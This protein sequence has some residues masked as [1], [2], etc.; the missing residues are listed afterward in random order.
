[1]RQIYINY[2]YAS[3]NIHFSPV[4][5]CSALVEH[6]ISHE[7]LSYFTS[8]AT[9]RPTGPE[10]S[11]PPVIASDALRCVLRPLSYLVFSL[12]HIEIQYTSMIPSFLFLS[13]RIQATCRQ[14]WNTLIR[15]LLLA[16]RTLSLPT[17]SLLMVLQTDDS[18][19]FV[20]VLLAT[21][22]TRTCIFPQHIVA[23]TLSPSHYSLWIMLLLWVAWTSVFATSP[24]VFSLAATNL[25]SSNPRHLVRRWLFADIVYSQGLHFWL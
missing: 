9:V 25:H 11:P 3:I 19:P 16:E 14:I 18:R 7:S 1:M 4:L 23:K 15:L 2:W 21:F 10:P 20:P 6:L 22:R 8:A 13:P 24:D 5:A 12:P 17:H